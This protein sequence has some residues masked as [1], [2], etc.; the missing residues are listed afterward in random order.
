MACWVQFNSQQ[1][2]DARAT[3][4]H[5]PSPWLVVFIQVQDLTSRYLCLSFFFLIKCDKRTP[6]FINAT[7][8][9][10][11]WHSSAEINKLY[12]SFFH[13]I[14]KIKK[15]LEHSF[16]I[17]QKENSDNYKDNNKEWSIVSVCFFFKDWKKK[18]HIKIKH[19]YLPV[20]IL[21]TTDSGRVSPM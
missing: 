21:V 4:G 8:R 17:W 1:R 5:A 11:E 12:G 2:Y 18:T 3:I 14:V 10:F 16:H 20:R 9:V 13:R 19:D 7:R 15:K 6:V